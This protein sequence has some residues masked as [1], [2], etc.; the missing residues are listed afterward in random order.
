MT[1]QSTDAAPGALIEVRDLVID[2]RASAAPVRAVDGVSFSIRPGETLAI[3]GESGSGKTTAASAVIGLLPRSAHIVSGTV[4]IEGRDVTRAPD[5]VRRRSRGRTI[6]LVPQDPLVSLNPT[7]TVGRQVGEVLIRKN[8]RRYPSLSADV[9]ELLDQVGLDDPAARA[10]QYPHQLSGG[11]R[12]RVLI[13]IALAGS[14]RVIIADEPTSALD[15]TVQKRILDHLEL[16]AKERGIALLIITHDLGVAADRADRVLVMREGRIVDQGLPE[17]ILVRPSSAYTRE[18]IDAAPALGSRGEL[19][20]RHRHVVPAA[21][22][23]QIEGV[24]KRFALPA[25]SGGHTL[26]ALENVSLSARRG[27]TLAVVGESGSGKTTLL[28]I[29]LGLERPT[30]GAVRFDGAPVTERSWRELKK[31]RKRMQLVQQNPFSSLDPRFSVGRS[32]AEPLVGGG[33]P[34]SERRKRVF[35]ML[36]LVHLPR[37]FARRLPHELS[38]GQRQRVAIA[39]ALAVDPEVLFLDEPVSALDVS[40][41]SRILALLAELQERLGIGYVFVSHDL[42]VVAQIAHE[43]AVLRRGRLVEFGAATQILENPV[44]EYTRELTEA[45]PGRH[46]RIA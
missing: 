12:Q 8:G 19:V 41:Q 45:V 27:Q 4:L 21:P 32:I 42:A 6:G 18:L 24:T 7:T 9:V 43:V 30:E 1:R 25:G 15:V 38:G 34:R 31:V 44:E 40:I 26:T 33:V 13:A 22:L 29:A 23:L 28:R 5:R 10:R 37:D 17:E 46:V 3:V 16:L 14:P 11:Q 20:A 39:R 2:Y 36:D 35:E